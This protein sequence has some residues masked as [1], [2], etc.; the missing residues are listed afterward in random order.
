MKQLVF[1]LIDRQGGSISYAEYMNLVLYHPEHGYYSST[2]QKIGKG[3]DFYTSSNVSDVYAKVF[4]AFFSRMVEK[5]LA[6]PAFCEIGGGTGRFLEALLLEWKNCSPRT[7][8]ALTVISVE[9][10]GFHR[11]LQMER[12]ADLAVSVQEQ[13]PENFRGIIFSNELFD[14]F[15][16]HVVAKIDSQLFEVKVAYKNG[17][18]VEEF[19]PLKNEEIASFLLWQN[20]ELSEG[21]RFEVPLAMLSYM[22]MLDHACEAAV[23][24]MADYGYT[25]AEWHTPARKQGSMRGYFRHQMM[26]PLLHPFEM[27]ITTHIHF[28]AYEKKAEELGWNLLVKERQD[29]F[30][31]NAGIL[32]FLHEHSHRDPFSPSA[33]QNRAVRDLIMPGGISSAFH[34]FLHGKGIERLTDDIYKKW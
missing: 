19:E 1:D 13:L 22:R 21:Q 28:D 7:Y 6:E 8:E 17:A 20:I 12:C 29:Q 18:L 2:R 14:A 24:A 3:G 4:A 27:D 26:P 10:S 9:G 25:N 16:V 11:N 31:M 5:D 33:K 23:I 15:P 32:S 30:L 34:V